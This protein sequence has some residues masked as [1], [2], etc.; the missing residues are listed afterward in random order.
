MEQDGFCYFLYTTS[1]HTSIMTKHRAKPKTVLRRSSRKRKAPKT[2]LE[3]FESENIKKLYLD[4][5][6]SQDL[7]F[8]LS[9]PL[10]VEKINA[11]LPDDLYDPQLDEQDLELDKAL[12]AAL[13]LDFEDFGDGSDED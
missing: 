11:D 7:S 10:T 9:S 2:Y 1:T 12:N 6:P 13:E 5:I 4:D 8:A 3:E